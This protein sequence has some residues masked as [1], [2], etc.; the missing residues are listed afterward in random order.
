MFNNSDY[1]HIFDKI[2]KKNAHEESSCRYLLS[3][4]LNRKVPLICTEIE[5]DRIIYWL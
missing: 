5:R 1:A 2:T 4:Q 3:F